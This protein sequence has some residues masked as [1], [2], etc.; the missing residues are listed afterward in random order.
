MPIGG[1]VILGRGS[2]RHELDEVVTRWNT[3]DETYVKPGPALSDAS[4]EA[5]TQT[6]ASGRWVVAD[7]TV[8]VI[9]APAASAGEMSGVVRP[10]VTDTVWASIRS[11]WV[12][13][14]TG[15]RLMPLLHGANITR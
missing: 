12:F 8:P 6:P 3:G 10:A 15:W 1:C 14:Q 9:L 2:A 11:L 4:D 5:V 13:H 7:V